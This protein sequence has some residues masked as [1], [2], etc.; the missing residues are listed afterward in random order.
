MARSLVLPL[1]RLRA[2]ALDI[3]SVQLPERVRQLGESA[4][5]GASLEMSPIDVTS[6]DEIGQV[7][8]AFDQVHAEAVRLA[9]N[10]ALLR[11]RYNAMFV[12]L[13]RRSQALIERLVRMIDSLEQNEEDPG[14]L[15]NLFAMDHLVT[16]MRRNSE[17]LLLLAG[18]EAARKWSEPVPLTD[19]AR[20]AISEIEQ[21]SRVTLNIQQGVLVAGAAVSDVVHLLAEVIENATAFSPSDTPVLMTAQAWSAAAGADRGGRQRGRHPGPAGGDQP[22]AGQPARHGRV[23]IAAH[24]AVRRGAAG[25]AAR[26]PG[27]AARPAAAG[28]DRHGVAAGQPRRAGDRQYGDVPQ[29][30]AAASR[31]GARPASTPPSAPLP[32]PGRQRPRRTPSPRAMRTGAGRAISAGGQRGDVE[33]VPYAGNGARN[34]T[35]RR[36]AGRPEAA[37]QPGG[38]LAAG[39]GRLDWDGRQ[40]A[41]IIAN[42]VRGDRTVAGM[43]VRVPHANLV[44]GLPPDGGQRAASPVPADG[45]EPQTPADAAAAIAGARRAA[46]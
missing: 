33:V 30:L 5:A 17:N 34:G 36:P 3:A 24:G 32:Q 15:S 40:A 20:A 21:Y 16:R 12:N 43:P 18:H 4:D 19:V 23:G 14:R 42:P 25:R 28:A 2:D 44:P 7:A 39:N 26:H 37:A 27:P 45:H 6:G 10:E 11:T 35:A 13:S 46:G 38:R 29:R 31:P 41:Q 22:A 8:R 9:G 1:R